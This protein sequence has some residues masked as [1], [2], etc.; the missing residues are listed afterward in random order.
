MMEKP[1]H[2]QYYFSL[3]KSMTFNAQERQRAAVGLFNIPNWLACFWMSVLS[4]YLIVQLVLL[5]IEELHLSHWA[6]YFPG[7]V[8]HSFLL[9]LSIILAQIS[10]CF[11]LFDFFFSFL[12][13][14]LPSPSPPL[15]FSLLLSSHSSF[16]FPFH[17]LP[18]PFHSIPLIFNRSEYLF[19][20]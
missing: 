13:C 19:S 8:S 10:W 5:L 11:S 16:P 9:N 20:K 15:V 7:K 3:Q 4:E 1:W 17:P 2:M 18:L 14:P 6:S 12:S